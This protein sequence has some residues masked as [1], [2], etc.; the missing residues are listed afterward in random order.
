MPQ[1]GERG[2]EEEEYIFHPLVT[3]SLLDPNIHL[4]TLKA[5]TGCYMPHSL[6]SHNW[7]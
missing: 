1:V 7:N 4:G 2:I 6:S 5:S 3:F